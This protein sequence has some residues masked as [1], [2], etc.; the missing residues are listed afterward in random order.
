MLLEGKMTIK[1]F[2]KAW[3]I[4]SSI[5]LLKVD[6]DQ[7]LHMVKQD[8]ERHSQFKVFWQDLPRISSNVNQ[9]TT[10][11][12]MET[13]W[14]RL[15]PNSSSWLAMMEQTYLEI[16]MQSRLVKTNLVRLNTLVSSHMISTM[17]MTSN[18]W[19][20]RLLLTGQ[21]NRL[22]RMIHQAGAMLFVESNLKT[23]LWNVWSQVNSTSLI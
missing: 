19:M 12:P 18:P 7:S 2:M 17:L 6:W 5:W 16:R 14:S 13:Q 21:L 20:I 9:E 15:P 1:K 4:H 10:L 23:L 22:L 8:Q 3:W 11:M